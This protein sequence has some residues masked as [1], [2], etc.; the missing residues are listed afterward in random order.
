MGR[1][2]EKNVTIITA[3]AMFLLAIGLGAATYLFF[4]KQNLEAQDE[5]KSKKAVLAGLQGKEAELN[6]YSTGNPP[7]HVPGW[8][9]KL[10]DMRK[11]DEERVD[12]LPTREE[13]RV[14]VFHNEVYSLARE[15]NV[16]IRKTEETT[17]RAG[18]R[19][20]GTPLTGAATG[21][22]ERVSYIYHVEGVF[23]DVAA[24]LSRVEGMKRFT[25]IVSVKFSPNP[26]TIQTT[27]DQKTQVMFVLLDME[28]AF[29][30]LPS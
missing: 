29:Y 24:F 3:A 1:M 22:Y 23:A 6:G 8:K 28:F 11:D 5:L 20:V 14:L 25:K 15:S 21:P 19:G 18:P 13:R 2:N 27:N 16:I 26:R 12:V 10:P 7:K 17:A 4:Y 9:D 30:F